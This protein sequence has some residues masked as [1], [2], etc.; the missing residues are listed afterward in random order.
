[1]FSISLGH[2]CDIED[3]ENDK[4]EDL[5]DVSSAWHDEAILIQQRSFPRVIQ[6]Y[7]FL[8]IMIRD[9]V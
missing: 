2:K 7:G 6:R 5:Q 3:E 8:L 4:L 9:D 1:M